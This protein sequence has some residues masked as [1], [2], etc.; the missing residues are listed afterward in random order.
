V[1]VPIAVLDSVELMGV[2]EEL[3]RASDDHSQQHFFS[4]NLFVSSHFHFALSLLH[5]VKKEDKQ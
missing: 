3:Q 5:P 2:I 4:Q 1:E